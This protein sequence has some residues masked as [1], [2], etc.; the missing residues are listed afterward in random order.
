VST[1][2]HKVIGDSRTVALGTT[3]EQ[4]GH[5]CPSNYIGLD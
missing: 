4:R 5:L 1:Y 2:I 3:G